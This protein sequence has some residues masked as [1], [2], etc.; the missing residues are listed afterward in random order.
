MARP[1]LHEE[2]DHRRWPAGR[3]CGCFGAGRNGSL[4]QR[5]AGSASR[6]ILLLQQ[7]GQAASEPSPMVRGDE[8]GDAFEDEAGDHGQFLGHSNPRTGKRW[9]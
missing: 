1:A 4:E 5:L 8:N 6:R 2:R 3:A 7:P 9:R